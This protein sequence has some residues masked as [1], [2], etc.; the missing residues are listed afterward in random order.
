M[1]K[2]IYS[3]NI[4]NDEEAAFFGYKKD[5]GGYYAYVDEN[6]GSASEGW[7]D[8]WSQFSQEEINEILDLS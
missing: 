5:E 2:K 6:V 7:R 4:A 3:E 8:Y 1:S